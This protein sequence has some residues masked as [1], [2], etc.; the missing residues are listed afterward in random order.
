MKAIIFLSLGMFA[1]LAVMAKSQNCA[2]P[3]SNIQYRLEQSNGGAMKPPTVL[4][5]LAGKILVNKGSATNVEKANIIFEEQQEVM[6]PV[7]VGNTVTEIYSAHAIIVDI[8]TDKILSD[9]YVICRLVK[10]VVGPF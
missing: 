1:S 9:D 3:D 7:K 10:S 8:K 6:A 2:S 4:L 5:K